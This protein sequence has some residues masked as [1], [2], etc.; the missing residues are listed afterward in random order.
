MRISANQLQLR[1]SATLQ[2]SPSNV[3]SASDLHLARDAANT[4]AQRNG[5]AAQAFNIYNTYT[6][7]SNYERL[8]IKCVLNVATI[9]AENSGTGVQM[10][11]VLSGANRANNIANVS[12]GTDT[13]Y[14]TA[15]NAILAALESHGIVAAA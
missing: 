8:A 13:A 6:D 2:W 1:N 10:D 9:A 7:A 14:E 12:S 3:G 5:A 15:I 11:I 4:L